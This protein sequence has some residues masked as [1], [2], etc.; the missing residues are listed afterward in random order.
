MPFGKITRK[1]VYDSRDPSH[2]KY[3]PKR[4]VYRKR[5][6]RANAVVSRTAFIPDRMFTRLKYSELM[7]VT[8]TGLA[9]PAIYQF[10]AHSIFDPNLTGTGHQPYGH[11]QYSALYN[12][13]RV[14]GVKY[15]VTFTN[16]DAGKQFDIGFFK[17]PNNSAASVV[18]TLLEYPFCQHKMLGA[19]SSGQA[20]RTISGYCSNPRVLGIT[21]AS[22][23][24]DDSNQALIGYNPTAAGPI[25]SAFISNQN[26]AESGTVNLRWNLEYY[27]EFF[28]RK[29]QT[30]S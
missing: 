30:Q 27:V 22:H 4:K 14:Y 1:M 3:A 6:R 2:K 24:N 17:R 16:Q 26:T 20:I 12:R 18:E 5:V 10:R 7:A 29:A 13:Y 11:D 9:A 23:R 21:R 28:D 15:S 8:Y 25:I 19:E